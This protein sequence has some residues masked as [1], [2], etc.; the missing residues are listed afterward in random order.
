LFFSLK[1][2]FQKTKTS[3]CL[4]FRI[5]VYKL[6]SEF[7]PC[8]KITEFDHF[9]MPEA[10]APPPDPSNLFHLEVYLEGTLDNRQWRLIAFL[11]QNVT[12]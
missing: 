4:T 1:K 7:S 8:S 10:D 9:L 11:S 6:F 3:F 5:V 2:P 12:C